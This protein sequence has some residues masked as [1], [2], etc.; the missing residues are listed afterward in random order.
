MFKQ[1]RCNCRGDTAECHHEVLL[2]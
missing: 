2:L 1:M